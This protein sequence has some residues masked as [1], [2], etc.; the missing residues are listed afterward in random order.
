MKPAKPPTKP[1]GPRP[2]DAR[3]AALDLLG[4]V[5]DR[6]VPLDT[7]LAHSAVLAKLSPR[8]RAFARVLITTVLRRRGQIDA[9]LDEKLSRRLTKHQ[10]Q[11][12]NALRLGVAQLAFLET[13]AHAAVDGSVNLVRHSGRAGMT[14]LVNAI[15]RTIDR[16]S[17]DALAA[18]PE[19]EQRNT[20]AWLRDSWR[21][22]YGADTAAAIMAVHRADPPL[23]ISLVPGAPV[24]EWATRLDAEILPTGSLRRRAGGIVSELDGFAEGTWWVQDAAAALPARLFGDL[25]GRTAID[26]CAAPGGKTAQL[27]AAGA[28][29]TALDISSERLR[30]VSQNMDRLGFSVKTVCADA[31]DYKPAA[32]AEAILLDAPCSSTGTIRRHPDIAWLK[33]PEDVANTAKTQNR[34][35]HAAAGMLAPGGTLVYAVCSLQP[36]EG[37]AQIEALLAETSD[38]VRAPITLDELPGLDSLSPP[39]LTE[40]GDIRTLPCHFAEAGGMDGFYIARLQRR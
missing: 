16:E 7:V 24:Q 36:E 40:Q 8:D 28:K 18:T 13:P 4:A 35:L 10:T 31:G 21:D 5:L 29:V 19:T 22:A 37:P 38:M 6:G 14:G 23:D 2:P 39:A 12:R 30:L 25:N 20:P 1:R 3:A 27:A 32:P 17:A 34:L 15:L 33:K 9:A 11:V 26:L